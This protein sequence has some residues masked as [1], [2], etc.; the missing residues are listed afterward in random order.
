MRRR[1]RLDARSEPW[2]VH[3]LGDLPY[4][5]VAEV[6]RER[7]ISYLDPG[8]AEH[9]GRKLRLLIREGIAG[10][11]EYPPVPFYV[12]IERTW[13]GWEIAAMWPVKDAPTTE[14]ASS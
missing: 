2:I 14:P 4:W 13:G 6:V 7:E 10:F 8:G 11:A 5:R 12:D 1:V 3:V 9:D